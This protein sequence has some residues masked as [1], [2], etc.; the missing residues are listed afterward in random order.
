[1]LSYKSFSQHVNSIFRIS[2]QKVSAMFLPALLPYIFLHDFLQQNCLSKNQSS[3]HS[4]SLSHFHRKIKDW[5]FQTC[6]MNDQVLI[7]T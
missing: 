1:M 6:N 5:I 7:H 2:T 4:L 3:V